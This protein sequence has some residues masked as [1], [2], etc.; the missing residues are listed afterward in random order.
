[1]SAIQTGRIPLSES[2]TL[3]ST[4]AH[5][6]YGLHSASLISLDQLCDNYCITVLD[7]NEIQTIKDSK[8]ILRGR[9]KNQ[10]EYGTY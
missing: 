3:Q 6:V 7:K 9:Q 4:K 10:M 5:N 8:L 1:M 2:I